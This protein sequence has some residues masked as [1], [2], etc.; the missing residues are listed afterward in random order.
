MVD[1]QGMC[2]C[3]AG[4]SILHL[5]EC[6]QRLELVAGLVADAGARGCPHVHGL[7]HPIRFHCRAHADHLH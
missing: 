1:L 6:A 4:P 2:W 5:G 7:G 3:T